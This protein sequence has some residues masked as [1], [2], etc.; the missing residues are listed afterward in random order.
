VREDGITQ[1]TVTIGRTVSAEGTNS[2]L[3][4]PA[5]RKS[6]RCHKQLRVHNIDNQVWNYASRWCT[7]NLMI[8]SLKWIHKMV[9]GELIVQL[10]N[11]YT[12]H[13]TDAVIF[14]A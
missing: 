12:A 6:Q 5:K 11:Q 4:L 10:I 2:P 8:F 13:I 14:L 7:D 1:R 9:D 3:V